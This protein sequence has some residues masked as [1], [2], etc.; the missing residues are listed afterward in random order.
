MTRRLRRVLVSRPAHRY[1]MAVP[2][3]YRHTINCVLPVR[4][5]VTGEVRLIPEVW[6]RRVVCRDG[7]DGITSQLWRVWDRGQ[8]IRG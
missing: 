7:G 8:V 5:R 3:A 6:I 4:D 1:V 2:R